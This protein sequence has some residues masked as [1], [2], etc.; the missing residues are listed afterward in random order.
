MIKTNK[1]IYG[2]IEE[3]VNEIWK[4]IDFYDMEAP[5]FDF[6]GDVRED[7]TETGIKNASTASELGNEW[8]GCK[9]NRD[10][11]PFKESINLIFGYYGGGYFDSIC[12][13]DEDEEFKDV[14]IRKICDATELKPDWKTVF[15]IIKKEGE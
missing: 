4:M 11:D 6:C 13:W 14:I 1:F 5:D 7:I 3:C 12:I 9:V 10:F 8:Y 15:E 2:T